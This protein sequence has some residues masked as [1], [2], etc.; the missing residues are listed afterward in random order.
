MYFDKVIA[1]LELALLE[2]WSEVAT[3]LLLSVRETLAISLEVARAATEM[4]VL[5]AETQEQAARLAAVLPNPERLKADRPGRYIR[6]RTGTLVS[7]QHQVSRDA[8][9]WCLK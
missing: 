2:P 6:R 3:E 5:L 1:V 4:R 7:R 9:D 8:L